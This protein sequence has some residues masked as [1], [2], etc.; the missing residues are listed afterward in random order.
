MKS[1]ESIPT[2]SAALRIIE[3]DFETKVER[4]I[5]FPTARAS[6]A[7]GAYVWIDIDLNAAEDPS[8]L[9]TGLDLFSHEI[10]E[11]ALTREPA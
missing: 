11:D 10:V 3:F 2:R 5:D 6:M 8:A 4:E 1:G 7:A 9:L